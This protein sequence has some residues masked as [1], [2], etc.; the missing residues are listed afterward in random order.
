MEPI[1]PFLTTFLACFGISVYSPQAQRI[2]IADIISLTGCQE[3]GSDPELG[4]IRTPELH[5][6]GS[7]TG[8]VGYMPC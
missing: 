8:Y 4:H 1:P 7:I 6:S 2:P 5:L 3:R